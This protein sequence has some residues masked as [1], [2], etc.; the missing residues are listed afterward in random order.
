MVRSM[1]LST[2]DEAALV[3]GRA[4][5]AVIAHAAATCPPRATRMPPAEPIQADPAMVTINQAAKMLGF[6]RRAI[7]NWRAKKLI[8]SVK[9]G[10]AVRIPASEIA[11]IKR[12]G[13]H[14]PRKP[15]LFDDA[16]D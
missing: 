3:I 1:S 2:D 6:S 16:A 5:L 12:D 15:R 9:I 10:E 8:K 14:K 11:R 7:C 4:L 13:L